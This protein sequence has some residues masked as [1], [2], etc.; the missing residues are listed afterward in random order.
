MKH[1]YLVGAIAILVLVIYNFVFPFI[2]FAF[3]LLFKAL[4]VLGLLCLVIWLIYKYL[5]HGKKNTLP[6][7]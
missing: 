7:A 5:T 1:L 3:G 4:M 6:G 2:M